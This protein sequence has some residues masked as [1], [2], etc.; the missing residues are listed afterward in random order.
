VLKLLEEQEAAIAS[1]VERLQALY[2]I[3]HT[4]S[5]LISTGLGADK[6]KITVENMDAMPITLGRTNNFEGESFFSAFTEFCVNAPLSGINLSYPVGGFF[7]NMQVFS[8]APS[9]PQQFFSVDP[10]GRDIKAKDLYLIAYTKGYYGKTNDVANRIL[11]FADENNLEFCGPVYNIYLFDEVS[12]Q[13]FSDYLLQVSVA[14]RTR[15]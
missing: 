12:V 6:D 4:I 11:K 1:E 13:N 2:A 9:Q 10:N 7:E 14:V 3:I 8:E 5:N 15:R